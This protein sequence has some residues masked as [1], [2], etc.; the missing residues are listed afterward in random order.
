[1][2]DHIDVSPT[3]IQRN[4][5]DVATELTVQYYKIHPDMKPEEIQEVYAQF[6][7]VAILMKATNYVNLKDFMSDK[8][9][10]MIDKRK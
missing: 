4:L 10:E 1:M 6:Y 3:P 2:S 5:N 8:L 7:A 9:K